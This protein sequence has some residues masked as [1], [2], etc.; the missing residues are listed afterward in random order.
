MR[1]GGHS[2]R[3]AMLDGAA[4]RRT[5]VVR[6]R[7]VEGHDGPFDHLGESAPVCA[8]LS[9]CDACGMLAAEV[10]LY[11]GRPPVRAYGVD[12]DSL[13]V[14]HGVPACRPGELSRDFPAVEARAERRAA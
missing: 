3:W 4:V 8:T 9:C 5:A 7:W 6:L 2:W 14:G 13:L 11:D 1:R 10:D 12:L